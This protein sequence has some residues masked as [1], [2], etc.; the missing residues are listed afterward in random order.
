MFKLVG[1]EKPVAVG[2]SKTWIANVFQVL[3]N[4]SIRLNEQASSP[5][6]VYPAHQILAGR[7]A[8][9]LKETLSGVITKHLSIADV[10]T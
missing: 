4:A 5:W 2:R 10:A 6:G 9:G 7:S 8:C 1:V 3:L